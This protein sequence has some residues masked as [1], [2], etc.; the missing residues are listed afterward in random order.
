MLMPIFGLRIL[1]KSFYD[2]DYRFNFVE[3]LGIGKVISSSNEENEKKI[4]WFHAV[5]LGEVIGSE[6]IIKNLVNEA[7]IFL[8]VTTPTGLRKAKEIYK[9]HDI[10][11]KYAP[12]DFYFFVLNFI[13]TNQPN[14]IIVFETE[15]WPSMISIATRKGIP[16]VV[17]N[18]RM[19]E[20]SFNSYKSLSFFSQDVFQKLTLVLAQS[21]AHKSRFINLGVKSE[22]LRIT[23]SVKYDL[24]PSKLSKSP[25]IQKFTD[26]K[27]ILAVSTHSG[28]DEIILKSFINITQYFA[29]LKLVIVPRHPERTDEIA[30]IAKTKNISAC[31]ESEG[32]NDD[33]LLMIVDSIGKTSF[34]YQHAEAAFVGGS[35]VHRGGHNIIEPAFFKCPIIIG[36]SMFN[37]ETIAE[38]FIT[39]K[40]CRVVYDDKSLATEFID[41]LNNNTNKLSMIDSASMIIEKNSGASEL[42]LSAIINELNGV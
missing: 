20:K 31:I 1:Y 28:E 23:G 42:Q 33:C 3:R 18:G 26:K 22:S 37:F 12:W 17:S 9:D 14:L 16:V 35:L 8:T 36:P 5:S 39:N 41:I 4:I 11:I 7:D 19:S 2:K 10:Q 24:K 15:V 25:E 21:S 38:D 29:N 32:V 6:N 34:L 40:A 27:F 30:K 13:N